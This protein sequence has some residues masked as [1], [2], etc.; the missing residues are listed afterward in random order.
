RTYGGVGRVTGNGGPYPILLRSLVDAEQHRSIGIRR[1]TEEI[2]NS[3][4][5]IPSVFEILVGKRHTVVIW[6]DGIVASSEH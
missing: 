1:P 4:K 2:A 6:V 5:V 3:G